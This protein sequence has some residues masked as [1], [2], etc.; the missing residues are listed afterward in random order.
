MKV[1]LLNDVKNLGKK[2]ILWRRQKAM[3][4]IT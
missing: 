3:A 2:A 4:V 1:I